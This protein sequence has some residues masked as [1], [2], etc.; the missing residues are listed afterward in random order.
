M[1]NVN[2]VP[3]GWNRSAVAEFVNIYGSLSHE[4]Y[5]HSYDAKHRSITF[6]AVMPNGRI[7]T[8]EK[9]IKPELN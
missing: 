8:Y 4:L 5:F 6:Q 9:Y 7:L 2:Y 1:N 3:L